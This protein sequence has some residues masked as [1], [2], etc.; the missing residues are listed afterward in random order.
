MHTH[1]HTH[2]HTQ[3]TSS[4][5]TSSTSPSQV[6]IIILTAQEPSLM[7]QYIER[8]ADHLDLEHLKKISA[9]CISDP[10]KLVE[11]NVQ[12]E[13]DPVSS[14]TQSLSQMPTSPS[15]LSKLIIKYSCFI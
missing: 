2:I 12:V 1:T 11:Q 13:Q 5:T 8:V 4:N 10:E 6:D 15:E 7:Q 14:I 3:G 9:V